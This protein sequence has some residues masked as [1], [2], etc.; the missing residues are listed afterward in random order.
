[1]Y[2]L[3]KR[4]RL[5]GGKQ[6]N[7]A[8]RVIVH[9]GS[10]PVDVGAG[11]DAKLVVGKNARLGVAE[12]LPLPFVLHLPFTAR[13]YTGEVEEI[14]LGAIQVFVT[15]SLHTWIEPG[16][17]QRAGGAA[18]VQKGANPKWIDIGL[19]GRHRS[20]SLQCLTQGQG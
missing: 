17:L 16:D 4:R 7:I 3:W 15:C 11:A 10:A 2:R 8:K 9:A 13:Q 18:V 6:W 19:H 12:I 14:S 20:S 5:S 1:M